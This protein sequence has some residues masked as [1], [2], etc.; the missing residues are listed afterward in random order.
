MAIAFVLEKE[1]DEWFFRFDGSEVTN[2]EIG[3]N[4]LTRCY[5]ELST[6]LLGF[7]LK[8]LDE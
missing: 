8:K 3:S 2:D 4:I 7:R 1:K 6:S 5:I